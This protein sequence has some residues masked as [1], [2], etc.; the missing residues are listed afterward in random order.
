[1]LQ[2]SELLQYFINKPV[3]TTKEVAQ[4]LGMNVKSLQRRMANPEA[5]RFKLPYFKTPT[6]QYR[7]AREVVLAYLDEHDGT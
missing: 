7:F 3:W 1:M 5:S 6:G 2:K 4:V